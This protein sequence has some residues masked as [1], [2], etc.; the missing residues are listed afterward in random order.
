MSDAKTSTSGGIL[1]GGFM[2]G[3]QSL[4]PDFS[5]G[6]GG[7]DTVTSTVNVKGDFIVGGSSNNWLPWAVIAFAVYTFWKRKK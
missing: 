3:L 6:V 5:S 1:D 4:T 2:S 7:S